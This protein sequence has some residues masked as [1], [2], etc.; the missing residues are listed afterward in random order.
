MFTPEELHQEIKAYHDD[1]MALLQKNPWL[2]PATISLTVVPMAIA[3]HG[4]WKNRQ[5]Q[6]QLKIEREKTKQMALEQKLA[7]KNHRKFRLN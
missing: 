5:L 1:Q 2:I 6:K 3:I 7:P 4:F